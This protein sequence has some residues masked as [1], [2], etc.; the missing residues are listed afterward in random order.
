VPFATGEVRIGP[1]ELHVEVDANDSVAC[2]DARVRNASERAIRLESVVLGFRWTRHGSGSLRFLRHGWQSW[3][4]TGSR[5]L[6]ADGEPAFPSGAW[7]RGL[8]HALGA[9][10][11]DRSGWHE[12]EL[13][14]V[15]GASPA[16]PACCVGVLERGRVFGIVYLRPEG[17]DVEIELELRLDAELAP[18]ASRTLDRAR[19]ALGLDAGALLEAHAEAHGRLADARTS[20]PFVSGWCSWYHFFQGVTEDDLLRNLEALVAARDELP[21]EMVQLDDGY[22][23]AVGDWLETNEKFPRGIDAVAQEIRAAGFVPGLWTAPFCAVEASRFFAEHRDWLLR[24]DKGPQRGLHHPGWS[25]DGAVYILDASR[26][27]VPGHLEALCR[28]LVE[29]GFRFLKLDF[30][31]VGAMQ[32][33]AHDASLGRAERL[34]RGLDALRRGAGEEVFLLGC[35]CPLGAA[36]GVV[37]GMRIGPDVAPTWTLAAEAAVPGL[38]ESLPATRSA[39]RSILARVWMHRRLWVNDPD[40]VGDRGQRRGTPLLRRRPAALGGAPGPGAGDA[41]DRAPGR[42]AGPSGP[43]ACAGPAFVGVR[44]GSGGVDRGRRDRGAAQRG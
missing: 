37:D 30:L 20:S 31:Y 16:G 7:L 17:E 27:E 9:S 33:V 41:G 34:R 42:R 29:R 26:P 11:D 22:Q 2:V 15:A 13:V 21:I 6:D 10:P 40:G 18:G 43:C 14:T 38:E 39:V 4:F 23:R 19:V 3:S 44:A 5:P 35:G 8:H 32:A 1:V 24:G 25:R 12:S 36:V 28:E